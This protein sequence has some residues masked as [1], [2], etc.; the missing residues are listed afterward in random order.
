MIAFAN[1]ATQRSYYDS[2]YHFAD[3]IA[4][5]NPRRVWHAL[6][7]LAPLAG[8]NFLDLG[9][10]VGWATRQAVTQGHVSRA[11]GVDFSRTALALAA[12]QTAR[13]GVPRVEWVL[14]DGTSLP[15]DDESFD[16]GFSFGSMEH[17]SHVRRGFA[18][19]ARVLRPAAL[20]VSVLPNRYA[21]TEQPL[22]HRETILGWRRQIEGVG[23]AVVRVGSDLG[24]SPCPTT[25]PLRRTVRRVL[26]AA[27]EVPAFYY[28]FIFVMRKV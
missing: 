19:L 5:P 28:Q 23:L 6:R 15:F 18:E 21:R 3:D 20:A 24:P 2:R 4:R 17:F 8:A 12:E 16:R 1:A 9:C 14:A 22:E 11:V 26:R 10:G 25:N 13:D 27:R 7:E